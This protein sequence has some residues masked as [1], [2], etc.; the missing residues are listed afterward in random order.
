[1]SSETLE[2]DTLIER[3][4]EYYNSYNKLGSQSKTTLLIGINFTTLSQKLRGY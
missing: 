4:I 3:V 2:Y 1:M